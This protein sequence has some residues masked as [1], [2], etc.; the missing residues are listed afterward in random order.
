MEKTPDSSRPRRRLWGVISVL[1]VAASIVFIAPASAQDGDAGPLG[2]ELIRTRA[3]GTEVYRGPSGY[4]YD[5]STGEQLDL[6]VIH[7]GDLYDVCGVRTG[8][9]DG[10]PPIGRFLV[11]QAR[12]GKYVI[13]TPPAG[14]TTYTS[15]YKTD[16]PVIPDFFDAACGGF[17][18]SGTPLPAPFATGMATLHRWEV[19][20]D[21]DNAIN[22]GTG[23]PRGKYRNGVE[24]V[25]ADA[26]GNLYD[27]VTVADFIKKSIDGP[28]IFNVGT[29]T[30]TPQGA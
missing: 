11:K 28:P 27:L 2:V 1:A 12:N 5:N 21:K 20:A 13:T 10:L 26:D 16:L 3:N 23:Q 7:G 15:V 14:F 6:V 25:V 9:A 24:G 17:F 22:V 29:V 8:D 18:G 4:V 19:V 30:L